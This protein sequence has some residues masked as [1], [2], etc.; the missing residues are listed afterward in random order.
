MKT[1]QTYTVLVIDDKEVSCRRIGQKLPG[2][3]RVDLGDTEVSIAVR[4]VHVRVR[5]ER[6]AEQ[7]ESDESIAV[8]KEQYESDSW[9]FKK[10]MVDELRAAAEARPDMLIVDYIYV[11]DQ[12]ATY[13]KKKAVGT[14]VEKSE[15][16]A[17]VLNP[18]DLRLWVESSTEIER[19]HRD[20]ILKNLFG[21]SGPL[22]LHTYTPQGLGVVSGTLAERERCTSLAF[23][24]ADITA[25]DTRSE[26]FNNEE[27]DWPSDK[28]RYERDYY[29]YQLATY[30]DQVVQKE[31]FREAFIKNRFIRFRRSSYAVSLICAVGAAVG[32]ASGWAGSLVLEF[33]RG[34][35][36][37]EAMA[38]CVLCLGAM[39][40]AGFGLT[41]WFETLMRKL[42]KDE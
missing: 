27:F 25:V 40:A 32:F 2:A 33:V 7:P 29:A 41:I 22:Y 11:D 3:R 5:R 38:V 37:L 36:F 1:Q 18:H 21:F 6:R 10:E 8:W 31:V 35:R 9:T 13:F 34:Q 16:E 28:P 4:T 26:L 20:I 42:V 17:R 39:L 30:F 15:I 24:H 12:L 19:G 23:P 14:Q